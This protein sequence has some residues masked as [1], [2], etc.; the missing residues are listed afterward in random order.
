MLAKDEQRWLDLCELAA[1]EKDPKKLR[2]HL[3]EITRIL[4][5]KPPPP[6]RVP[7]SGK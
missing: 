1:K 4:K 2:Q 5:A 3:Q 7:P 6:K